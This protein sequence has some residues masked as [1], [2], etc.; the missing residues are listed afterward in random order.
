MN[1]K[2]IIRKNEDIQNIINDS[3][4]IVNKYFI[5]YFSCN[6][7]KHNRYCVSISKKLGKANIRNL[8]KRRIKDILMKNNINNSY[9]YVI[10]V[11]KSILDINYEMIKKE[12]LD[13][14]KG[15]KN[16]RKN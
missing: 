2:Y 15:N 8:Y 16:E 10:I 4:K 6:D 1:K 7:L 5:I 13:I 9:D 11:R 14:M 12:L 3:K